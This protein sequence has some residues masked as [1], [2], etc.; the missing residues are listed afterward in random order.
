MPEHGELLFLFAL[1]TT[2]AHLENTFTIES[3]CFYLERFLFNHCNLLTTATRWVVR[4][5]SF[6][7]A[8]KFTGLL[9]TNKISHAECGIHEGGVFSICIL[10]DGSI[11]SGGKD[12]RIVKWDTSYKKTGEEFEV[13][14]ILQYIWRV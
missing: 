11:V 10:R 3:L 2:D 5:I 6:M 12:R 8:F 9:G 4:V 7:I 13:G 14:F 1:S